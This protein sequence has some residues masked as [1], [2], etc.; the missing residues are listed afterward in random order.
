MKI[1]VTARHFETSDD[2]AAHI[3]GHLG[4][5]ERFFDK[6]TE[7]TVILSVEKYRHRA[8]VIVET[9]LKKF[10][11]E[12]ITDDMYKSVDEAVD[13]TKRQLQRYKE[14]LKN[15]KFEKADRKDD[16]SADN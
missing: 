16:E 15:H 14:K 10:V 2:L 4:E 6:A 13:K 3:E 9:T 1:T 12:A 7:A 8:E 5:I 11:S